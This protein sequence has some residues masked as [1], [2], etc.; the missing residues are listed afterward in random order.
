MPGKPS[1][2]RWTRLLYALLISVVILL[3]IFLIVRQDRLQVEGPNQSSSATSSREESDRSSAAGSSSNVESFLTTGPVTAAPDGLNLTDAIPLKTNDVNLLALPVNYAQGGFK[4]LH[5][6]P[7]GRL[8]MQTAMRLSI[9][10][11]RDM[12]EIVIKTADFGLQAV[13]NDH[14]IVFG[15]GGDEVFQLEVYSISGGSQSIILEDVNGYFGFEIDE[16]DHFY[17]TKVE[18]LKYGKSIGPWLDYDLVGGELKT[19]ND[20]P[21]S[22]GLNDLL[23]AIP[24]ADLDWTYEI[25]QP[26]FEAWRI[27]AATGFALELSYLDIYQE[28]YEYRLY[29]VDNES[30]EAIPETAETLVGS[31][32]YVYASDKIF[33]FDGHS[34]FDTGTDRWYELESADAYEDYAVLAMTPARDALYLTK[35]D[36]NGQTEGL[37]LAPIE[38]LIIP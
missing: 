5:V 32:P 30:H 21:H 26:W 17:T 13:A 19:V 31:R 11:P 1:S 23:A 20:L 38:Q 37:W 14:F 9:V 18:A 29:R 28:Q 12:S 3:V 33:V 2:S 22:L 8:I 35:F 36:L 27:D 24:D 16:D 10:D 34:F 7:D 6:L 25:G 4:L 15:V